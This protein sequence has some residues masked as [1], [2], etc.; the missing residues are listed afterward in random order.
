[1]LLI[2]GTNCSFTFFLVSSL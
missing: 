2:Y 1:M